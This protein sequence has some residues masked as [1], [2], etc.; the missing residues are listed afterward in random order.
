[1]NGVRGLQNATCQDNVREKVRDKRVLG[2]KGMRGVQN[3]KCQDSV[4]K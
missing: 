4:Q 1:M 3:A 2:V